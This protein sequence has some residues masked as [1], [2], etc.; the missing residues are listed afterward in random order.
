MAPAY[1][2]SVPAEL[3][4][5]IR[6]AQTRVHTMPR[7]KVLVTKAPLPPILLYTDASFEPAD[8]D[9]GTTHP[10]MGCAHYP[11]RPTGH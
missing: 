8:V 3:G 5:A 11:Q 4:I 10:Q 7:R 2:A 6:F 9:P 1:M